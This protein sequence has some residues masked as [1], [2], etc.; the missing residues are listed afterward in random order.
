MISIQNVPSLV[1]DCQNSFK[2]LTFANFVL[3]LLTIYQ[4]YP[5]DQ[6][7][8]GQKSLTCQSCGRFLQIFKKKKYEIFF[9]FFSFPSF[10]FFFHRISYRWGLL[11]LDNG[12]RPSP[13]LGEGCKPSPVAGKGCQL[14]IRWRKKRKR[15]RNFYKNL[16]NVSMLM[17]IMPRRTTGTTRPPRL[18][19]SAKINRND[20]WNFTQKLYN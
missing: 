17:L 7:W 11:G 3:N 4:C 18:H 20:L 13:D 6:F 9:F 19:F 16:Q 10:L 15:I 1:Y 5:S 2:L 8:P 12:Q 14:I